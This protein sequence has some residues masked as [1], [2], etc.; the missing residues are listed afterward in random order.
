M[1]DGYALSLLANRITELER[2]Y[3]RARF[4]AVISA[5]FLLLAVS[6]GPV[7]VGDPKGARTEIAS[8]G[9]KVYDSA[10]KLHAFLGLNSNGRPVLQ[11]DVIQQMGLVSR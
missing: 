7:V 9:V 10:G 11:M 8:D 1:N 2:S 5:C 6:P 4:C 3:R